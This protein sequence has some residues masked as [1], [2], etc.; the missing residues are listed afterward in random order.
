MGGLWVLPQAEAT[1]GQDS[2]DGTTVFWNKLSVLPVLRGSR[3]IQESLCPVLELVMCCLGDP[4]FSSTVQCTKCCLVSDSGVVDR[5]RVV[6]P[7]LKDDLIGRGHLNLS[8]LFLLP[9][10]R[11][12]SSLSSI[13][14]SF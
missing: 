4:V 12:S 9:A 2:V 3:G 6:A 10:L 11:G 1:F 8:P 7:V 13:S 14:Y 5:P